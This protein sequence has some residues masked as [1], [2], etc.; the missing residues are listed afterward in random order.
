MS[1]EPSLRV[2]GATRQPFPVD[3]LADHAAEVAPRLLGA[4]LV[5]REDDG[6]ETI[7][8]IVET[9]AYRES[10]PASH[11]FRG[12][13]DRTRAMFERAGLAYVYFTYGMHFCVNVSCEE[14]GIGAAVLLRAA[15]PLQ[16]RER[17]R[18]RRGEQHRERD[19]LAGPARLAEGL[20]I[21]RELYG[22]DLLDGS[23]PLRLETDGW[24]P[25]DFR[26]GP[27]VGVRAAADVPWRFWVDDVPEVSRYTRHPKA[28][29]VG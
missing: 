17:I 19:L 18:G 14:Q 24:A 25:T 8:R 26:S 7:V 21:D 15:V 16:G 13:T 2:V 11:S 10:D 6:T 9:E 29:D 5:R 3:Q 4:L 28:P 27:R 12:R 1:G 23:S 20:A 22:T